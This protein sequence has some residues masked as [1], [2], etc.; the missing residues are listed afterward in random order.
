MP[1]PTQEYLGTS[2]L[3]ESFYEPNTLKTV[4]GE[5]WGC[6]N[7]I[8]QIKKVLLHRPGIELALLRQMTYEEEVDAQVLRDKDGKIISYLQGEKHINEEL[9]QY[10]HDQLRKTLELYGAEVVD[11]DFAS[12]L[13][14]K[15]VYTRDIG[16]VVPSGVILTRFALAMRQ[17]EEKTAYQTFA[18]LGIPI[19]A[20]IQGDGFIEGGSFAMLDS[21]TA[22]IGRSVR[23]NQA[24]IDQLR[25]ILAWQNIDLIVVDVPN[26]RIHL[27][28]MFVMV[29]YKT[30]LIEPGRLPYWFLTELRSRGLKLIY[31]DPSDPERVANCL[32]VSPGKV[33]IA[34]DAHRTM[35]SLVDHGIEVIPIEVTEIRKLGGGI[36]CSTLPLMREDI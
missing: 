36:H 35:E 16:L 3:K 31:T 8:G 15:M 12:P 24:G 6:S 34:V 17:G 10:Q 13:H 30:A 19:L 9:L 25:Q 26:D 4:W 27:D 7:Y 22:I 11:V 2:L 18:K 33:L 29:D 14:T 32:A 23:V 5:Q 20:S 28:E 1:I 21:K